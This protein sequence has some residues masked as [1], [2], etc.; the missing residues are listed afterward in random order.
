MLF[1]RRA[2]LAAPGEFLLKELC[3][4]YL[5]VA[6]CVLL[7]LYVV[8]LVTRLWMPRIPEQIG[9]YSP[10]LGAGLGV[11]LINSLL[12]Y[13]AVWAALE[14]VWIVSVVFILLPGIYAWLVSRN[15]QIVAFSETLLV[16]RELFGPP[17]VYRWEDVKACTKKNE[18]VRSGGRPS[19][20]YN[21]MMYRLTLPDRV[22]RINSGEEAGRL[23]LQVFE[24]KRPELRVCAGEQCSPLRN[25][26]I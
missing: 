22:I 10:G 7:F 3:D 2:G 24:R 17:V 18:T 6:I 8:Y 14:K 19:F 13:F 21:Y 1:P 20:T 11:L 26:R 23:F 15:V 9:L 16:V 25:R 12:L 4:V 5:L